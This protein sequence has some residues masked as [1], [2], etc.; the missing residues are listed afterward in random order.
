RHRRNAPG[1]SVLR[2]ARRVPAGTPGTAGVTKGVGGPMPAVVEQRIDEAKQL[3]ACINDLVGI[4]ALPAIWS[5][6]G[7][8]DIARTLTDTLL[9]VLDLDFVYLRLKQSVGE[10]PL[11]IVSTGDSC[12]MDVLP[13]E[14]STLA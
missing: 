14:M 9:G 1:E 11:E 7:P 10:P 13:K 12:T 4:V 3:R 6:A 5:G 8:A 2:A